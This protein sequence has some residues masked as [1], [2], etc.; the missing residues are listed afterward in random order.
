MGRLLSS[1]STA[2]FNLVLAAGLVGGLALGDFF[3]AHRLA[4]EIDVGLVLAVSYGLGLHV[5]YRTPVVVAPT[6]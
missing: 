2:Q 6:V 3:A 4:A 1:V 5:A